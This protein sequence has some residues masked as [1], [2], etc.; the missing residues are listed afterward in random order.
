LQQ[1][2]RL[3]QFGGER[4]VK[5]ENTTPILIHSQPLA[6][7]QDNPLR[8]DRQGFPLPLLRNKDTRAGGFHFKPV[9]NPG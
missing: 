9:G 4:I 3:K 5:I 8:G 7:L 6:W 1:F 2:S